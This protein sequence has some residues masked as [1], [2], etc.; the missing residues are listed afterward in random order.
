MMFQHGQ[1]AIRYAPGSHLTKEAREKIRGCKKA[2]GWTGSDTLMIRQRTFV[3]IF[4][5]QC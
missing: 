5:L 3:S 1:I 2:T 4:P